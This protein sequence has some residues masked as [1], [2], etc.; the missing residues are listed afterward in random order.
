MMTIN[1]AADA[2]AQKLA[3]ERFFLAHVT[4]FGCYA[5]IVKRGRKWFIECRSVS[6]PTAFTTKREAAERVSLMTVAIARRH[7]LAALRD[8]LSQLRA[9]HAPA[10]RIAY[11]ERC[12]A[13]FE[14]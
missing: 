4:M 11:A 2:A 3:D 1:A 8:E 10:D 14:N 5:A 6:V 7:K 12:V 9:M 13:A